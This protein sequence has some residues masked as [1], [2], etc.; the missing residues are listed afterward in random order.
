MEHNSMNKR[1]DRLASTSGKYCLLLE[2]GAIKLP[3]NS[4]F[5]NL[6]NQW[7]TVDSF[8]SLFS[9][10]QV[11]RFPALLLLSP[12]LFPRAR[13]ELLSPVVG[14]VLRWG[15]EVSY[16][17]PGLWARSF[18][19]EISGVCGLISNDTISKHTYV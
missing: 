9:M 13:S 18:S 17:L 15:A 14:V 6:R 5:L 2:L 4:F 7:S 19:P 11:S 3:S 8:V 16:L 10:L 1:T 12:V